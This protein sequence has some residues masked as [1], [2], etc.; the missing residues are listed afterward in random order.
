[1]SKGPSSQQDAEPGLEAIKPQLSQLRSDDPP[2]HGEAITPQD[3]T[4][5]SASSKAGR[6]KL[7]PVHMA[8][9][10]SFVLLLLAAGFLFTAK[11]VFF[12]LEPAEAQIDLSGGL[13][14]PVGQGFL[15][16]PGRYQ[17][18][19]SAEGYHPVN[20][21]LAIGEAQN[22]NF[23]YQLEKLPGQLTV[24]ANT[25]DAGEVWIDGEKRAVLGATIP[26]LPAGDHQLQIL[27]ERYKP[28]TQ[29]VTIEGLGRHQEL[30]VVLEPAWAE[31]T[32]K[33]TPENAEL[34][35]DGESLG[36]T[37]LTAEILEGERQ[38]SVRLSGHKAWEET[39]EIAAGEALSLPPIQLQPADGLVRV[40]TQ[41][42]QA[43][44]TVDGQYMGLTPLELELAPDQQ[45]RIT[46]FKDGFQPAHREIHVASGKEQGIQ[47]ALQ[48][49]LGQIQVVSTPADA[50]LY[51]DDRL[52]GRANQTLSLPARQTNIMVRKDGYADYRTT[53]L[54]RPAFQQ[55]I[56]VTL[57]TEEEA[58]WAQIPATI[59][60]PGGQSLKLFRPET[61]FTMG[62]SRREQG[63]RANEVMREVG[64][65]RAFYLG[66]HE[67]RNG[68]FRRF[69]PEHSSG[70]A[71]GQSLDMDDRPVVRVSWE[72]A[73]LYCNWL[74]EAA[75]LPPFYRVENGKVTGFNPQATG[76]RL[77]TEAEWAW[78][79]RY[80]NGEMLK[81]PWGP[82]LPPSQKVANIADRNAAPLVGYVQPGYDD[83]YP[84]TAPVGSFPPNGKGLYDLAGNVAEWV[85]DFYEISVSLSQ[86]V[87]QDPVGPS[88][89]SY[90]VIRGSSWA[91]GTVTELRLSFRDYGTEPRQ[92][93]GFRIAR[94]VE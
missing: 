22:Q 89:G 43:S 60:S 93:V 45:H 61:S 28:F 78:A 47:V 77:P 76:Y 31:V 51:V 84:A 38:L 21:S 50:L 90:H 2:A 10:G 1:M 24:S 40:E 7:R 46:I 36:S 49:N 66:T 48:A 71:K 53:V 65:Q 79:A 25:G 57:K 18:T 23:H 3:F 5:A 55:S 64:L 16:L 52:M 6:P 82:Q 9:A 87:E 58:R 54:P 80:E 27:T 15:M 17:I 83:S 12:H 85:N 20:D 42:S 73:A 44:I 30:A 32:V 63:R 39:V 41:P 34:I 35:V 94:Y 29:T 69:K 92:D 74:S 56:E 4:P 81:Y 11:S 67:V 33:S 59:R 75:G 88:S 37:P 91:H 86:A 8:L 72:D 62:S 68:E 13:H 19:L 26:D 70:H 14:L